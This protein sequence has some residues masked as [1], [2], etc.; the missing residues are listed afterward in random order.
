MN[1][2]S[3]IFRKLDETL[4]AERVSVDHLLEALHERGFGFLLLLFA[5][6][7]ALP[8]PVPPVINV[9]L[10]SPMI[11]LTAQQ[12]IGRHTIWLPQWM[13]KKDIPREKMSKMINGL[14]PWFDRLESIVK[15]RMKFITSGVFSHLIGFFGLIM[16]L[17]VCIPLP[18]TNTVPSLGIALMSIGVISR[19]G[20]AVIL[21]A[22]IGLAWVSML[23]Y[24][25]V[26]FGMEGFE[27]IKDTIKSYI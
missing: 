22:A 14:L 3:D 24:A 27:L 13:R 20:L 8:I 17:A 11:L 2:I 12:A 21:G 7:M 10:A 9:M 16:A 15:P 18:L 23:C 4:S 1:S 19:D 5:A 25:F 26:F 6:P